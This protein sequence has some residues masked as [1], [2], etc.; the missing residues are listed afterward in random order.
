MALPEKVKV[1]KP[2]LLKL[3]NGTYKR[4]DLLSEFKRGSKWGTKKTV[5]EFWQVWSD[6]DRNPVYADATSGRLIPNKMLALGQRVVIAEVKG[7]RALVYEDSKMEEFPTIPSYAKSIGWVPMENLLLWGNCPTDQRGVTYKALIAINL[8]KVGGGKDFTGKVYRCPEGRYGEKALAMDMKFYFI[9]K[10][11]PDGERALLSL[12]P[13]VTGNNLYGW[14]DANSFSRWDQRA[15]LEPNWDSQFAETHKGKTVS[16]YASQSMNS[17][18]EVTKWEY[19]KPNGVNNKEQWFQ[20]R[21]VPQQLRFPILETV[22]E[23]AN[24]VHCTSFADH[25]GK[26]NMTS[27]IQRATTQVNDIRKM[28]QQLNIILVVEATTEMKTILPAIKASLAKCKSFSTQD[29]QLRTGLV[30]Y[31]SASQGTDG[32]EVVPLTSYDDPQITSKLVSDK[33][34]GRLSD[35]ERDV[36]LAQAIEM[37]SNS[38]TMNYKPNNNN[39]MLIVGN[40][41]APENNSLNDPKLQKRLVDNN[42]QIMSIQIMRNQTGSWVN[43]NDQIIDLIQSNVE[44]QY[45]D[46]G[47]KAQ[48]SYREKDK[49]GHSFYS[50]KNKKD[51][52]KSVLFAQIRYPK[53]LGK[54]LTAAEVTKYIDNGIN[55]YVKS[56]ATWSGHFEEALGNIQFDQQFLVK[57]LGQSGFE[58]WKKVKAISAFDGYTRLKDLN[59][60]DYWHYILYLSG[61]E[62]QKL[63]ADLEDAYNVAKAQS[64]ERGPYVAAMKELVKTHLGQ[65]DDKGIDNMDE[66]KLQELIYGLNVHTEM[67]NRRRLKDIADPRTVT[68]VEYRKM[69]DAFKNNYEKL[70]ELYNSGYTYRVKMENDF[71]YWVP[72]EDLP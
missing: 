39:L 3:S 35:K 61:G 34:N 10:E 51:K 36:A 54:A 22:N 38:S 24:W 23:V 2:E 1:G 18:D 63:L 27:E 25:T 68:A 33:A 71:Y 70:L 72:I 32:I 45:A 12:N 6:R 11:T 20:Y 9:M 30:L 56:T 41:G 65:K 47:D 40:R 17:G 55:K 37:A 59:G 49:D 15:C 29:L 5:K 16:V 43:F 46:I 26:A 67:T 44:K 66:D 62:L 7:D 60:N 14:V 13:T 53:E 31:R 8:N 69:L 50:E 4:S 48:F 52:D 57:Y 64:D 58:K 19:G 42:M 21:M 28:R